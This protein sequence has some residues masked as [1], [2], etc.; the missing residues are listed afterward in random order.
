MS[1][2]DRNHTVQKKKELIIK[3][4]HVLPLGADLLKSFAFSMA[5]LPICKKKIIKHFVIVKKRQEQ[6]TLFNQILFIIDNTNIIFGQILDGLVR[7]LP[8]FLRNLTD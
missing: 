3:N 1:W 5:A 4:V 7:H 2:Q 6:L 8:K